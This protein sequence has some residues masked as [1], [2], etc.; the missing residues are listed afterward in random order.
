MLQSVD[1][2]FPYYVCLF[3]LTILLRCIRTYRSRPEAGASPDERSDYRARY[4]FFGFELV[5][6]AAG[7]FILLSERMPSLNATVLVMYVMLVIV[8]FSLEDEKFGR[9]VKVVGH[10][11]ISVAVLCITAFAFLGLDSLRPQHP[12]AP[13]EMVWRVAMPYMDQTLHW[14]FGVRDTPITS[15]WVDTL[16]ADSR[17][18][19][20][21]QATQRFMSAQGPRLF[22]A[23]AERTTLNLLLLEGQ[24]VAESVRR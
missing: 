24:I 7:V 4:A 18:E 1:P 9:R 17:E 10:L 23:G 11:G 15:V 5:N 16:P 8:G 22:Q 3:V 20:V 21:K 19:A 12:P 13:K 6:V 2:Q 14:H